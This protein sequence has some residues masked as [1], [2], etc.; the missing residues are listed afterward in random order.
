MSQVVPSQPRFY[1]LPAIVALDDLGSRRFL[2]FFTAQIRNPN[3]RRSYAKAAVELLRWCEHS[4]ARSLDAITPIHVAGWVQEL[5]RSHAA[6]T[7]KQRLAAVRHLFDWL[8]TGHVM[9]TNPAHSVRGPKH[10]R[11]RGKTPVLAPEEARQ[12]LDSIPA[13]T[14]IGKRDRALIGL[15]T[16]TFARIGAASSMEVKDVYPQNRRLWVR[17]HEKGG[18][19]VELPCHHTLEAYLDDYMATAG[20]KADLRAPLF[21]TIKRHRTAI[22]IRPSRR[23][24]PMPWFNAGPSPPASARPFVITPSAPPAS[25]PTSRTVG[26]SRR[27]PTLPIIVNTHDPVL[28]SPQR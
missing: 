15:M 20:L 2:E 1:A 4:G 3:T 16:Y 22:W 28:R 9:Q 23:P 25:P 21:Q 14:L 12:L 10:S 8:V 6:P 19:Q 27:Q 7:A 5:T 18:K 13:D 17:L 24:K 26:R 11:K